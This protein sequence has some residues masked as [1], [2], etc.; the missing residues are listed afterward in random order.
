MCRNGVPHK[1]TL[2]K[3]GLFYFTFTLIY[4]IFSKILDLNRIAIAE[5]TFK[6]TQDNWWQKHVTDHMTSY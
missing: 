4:G 6:V 5:M 3:Y 2:Y 1:K